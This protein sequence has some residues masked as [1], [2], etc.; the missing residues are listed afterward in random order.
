MEGPHG[1]TFGNGAQTQLRG[2]RM[3]EKFLHMALLLKQLNQE[4]VLYI[5]N[6]TCAILG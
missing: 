5:L 6:T 4:Y 1:S 2:T 3:S